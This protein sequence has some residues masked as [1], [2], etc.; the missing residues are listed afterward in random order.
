MAYANDAERGSLIAGLRAL[1]TFLEEHPGV[2]APR[3]TDVLVFPPGSTDREMQ[4][5]VD[6]IA[7]LIESEVS[8]ETAAD[9]H[10]TTSRDFGPVQYRAVAIPVRVRN[11]SPAE[12]DE[13]A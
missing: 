5:E 13:E 2:P 11:P 10:Y 6:A 8:D 12:S 4:R 3:W 9:S 7:A 1:A